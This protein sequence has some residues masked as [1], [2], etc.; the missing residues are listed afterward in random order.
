M[1]RGVL[2]TSRGAI[3]LHVLVNN[4]VLVRRVASLQWSDNYPNY[5]HNAPLQRSVYPT[6]S[7]KLTVN[8]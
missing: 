8:I 2:Q 5:D 4:F 7:C 6:G 1:H 3:K